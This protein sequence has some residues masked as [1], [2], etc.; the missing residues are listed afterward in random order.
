MARQ[1]LVAIVLSVPLLMPA[2]WATA[3]AQLPGSVAAKVEKPSAERILV[4]N[5]KVLIDI[6]GRG[7]FK[8][9]AQVLE[10]G[11]IFLPFGSV[12]AGGRTPSELASEIARV[13]KDRGLVAEPAVTVEIVL[14]ESP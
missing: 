2:G 7:G 3:Q 12:K 10:D 8:G 6:S 13:V 9:A 1:I 5:D 4:A 14:P 11:L